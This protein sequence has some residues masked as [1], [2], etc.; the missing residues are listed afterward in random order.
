MTA[1]QQRQIL[2][3]GVNDYSVQYSTNKRQ[4]QLWLGPASFLNHGETFFDNKKIL[5]KLIFST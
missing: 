4:S 3:E 1:D 5:K 2:H